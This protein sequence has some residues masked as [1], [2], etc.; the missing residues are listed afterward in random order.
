M[1]PRN[2]LLSLEAATA[3]LRAARFAEARAVIED[4]LRRLPDDRRPRAFGE[5][6]RWHYCHGAALVGL[7]Q[8]DLAERE[9]RAVLREDA[10]EWLKGRAHKELGKLADLAGD[11]PHA[12]AEYRVADRICEAQHDAICSRETAALLK[13]VYR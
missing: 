3:A 12:V 6:A 1:F 4:A 8:R 2:R 9:L 13:S 5:A 10:A 7:H 11:R